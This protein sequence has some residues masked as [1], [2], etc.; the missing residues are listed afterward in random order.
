MATRR[1]AADAVLVATVG[2]LQGSTGV[3][4]AATGGV[5]AHVPQGTVPPYVQVEVPSASRQ[6]TYGRLGMSSMVSVHVVTQGQSLRPGAQLR[7]QCERAAL[8]NAAWSASGH[9]VLGV[10]LEG[11]EYYPEV[12]NGVVHHHHLALLRMWTEQTT[13]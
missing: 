2:R 4:S 13:S 9:D 3:T 1:S 7:D 8:T 12:V 11:E 10:S 5:Y 6:D